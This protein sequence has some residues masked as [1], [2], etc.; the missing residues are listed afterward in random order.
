[1]RHKEKRLSLAAIWFATICLMPLA[2][3][4]QNGEDERLL[5]WHQWRG[6]LATG[7]APH[8]DPPIRWDENTNIR[9]KAPLPGRGT[10]TPVIWGDRIFI[11]TA[12]E[13]DRVAE[14][15]PE[16][17]GSAGSGDRAGSGEPRTTRG[18]GRKAPTQSIQFV[19]LC[20]DRETGRIL[21]RDVAAEVVPH[22]GHHPTN[23][24][25]AASPVTDGRYV[26][27]WFGSRGLFCYDM[28]GKRAWQV[29]LGDFDIKFGFG[30]GSS[31]ALHEDT[32]VVKCDHER[33]SFITALSAAIGR[34]KWKTI[35]DEQSTWNTPLV[36]LRPAFQDA[37][38][39]K[40]RLQ[41]IVTGAQSTQGYDFQTGE[42]IWKYLGRPG[43]DAI[44]SPLRLDDLA[45][46]TSG[47]RGDPAYAVPLDSFGELTDESIEW[48]HTEGTPQIST[49]A[50]VGERL[51]FIKG[52]RGI[53]TC[54]NARTGRVIIDQ[55]RLP[56]LDDIYASPVAAADRV[57]LTDRDGTT[58]VIGA[59]A[60]DARVLA[61]NQLDETIHG[62]AAIAG[63]EIFIRGESHLYCIAE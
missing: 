26:Y 6:P 51:Y 39:G 33:E 37:T 52:R 35:R 27:C 63:R 17:A 13:T 62:S 44:P 22:Q 48:K 12:I 56:G 16:I 3:R 30:E 4:G 25:A 42:P 7:F 14:P 57:Y 29:D 24:F 49:P 59:A 53:L 54:L 58:V 2:G 46:C 55:A 1:M 31:P 15:A 40:Q 38:G 61:E 47:F 34:A 21:W 8:G 41:V 23:S 32:L 20:L 28:Q 43:V 50:L 9:W 45:I 19:V 11:V 18:G 60:D 10:C 5:H 36:A